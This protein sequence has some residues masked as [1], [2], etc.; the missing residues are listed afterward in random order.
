MSLRVSRIAVRK[1]SGEGCES[2]VRMPVYPGMRG[3]GQSRGIGTG[4]GVYIPRPPASDTAAASGGRPTLSRFVQCQSLESVK[5]EDVHTIAY[6]LAQ[7]DCIATICQHEF[8]NSSSTETYTRIPSSFVRGVLIVI[9]GIE[10]ENLLVA[11]GCRR[12]MWLRCKSITVPL[13][14]RRSN[15]VVDP[16]FVVG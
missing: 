2:A 1:A 6:R 10:V 13:R 16:R 9:L 5:G 8:T 14:L 7:R 4:S 15:A 3:T 11:S 12:G